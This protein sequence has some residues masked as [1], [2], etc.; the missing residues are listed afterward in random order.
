MYRNVIFIVAGLLLAQ[1][2]F[3]QRNNIWYFGVRGGLDFNNTGS[4][5][6]PAVLGNSAMVTNEG[7]SSICD[8]DGNLLFYSNGVTVYNR[9]HQVMLNGDNLAGDI[10]SVQACI[11]VPVPGN[12]NLFYIFTSDALEH[13]F[14]NGYTYSIVN[15]IGDGGKGEV[16]TKNAVLWGSCTERMVAARHANGTDVWLITNDNNSN[17]FRSWLINCNGLIT[18]PVVSSVGLVMNQHYTT[19]NGMLKVSPDAKKLCQTH[20]PEPDVTSFTPNFFQLF[21]FDNA[22]GAITNPRTVTLSNARVL[23]CEFSSDSKLLYLTNPSGKTIEQVEATLPTTSAIASSQLTINTSPSGYYGIQLAPDG[24]IYLADIGPALGAIN[25]PDVKGSGCNYVNRQITLA[26]GSSYL[27]LPAYINDFSANPTNG[28]SSSILDSCTGRVQFNSFTSMPGSIIWDWDFGDG[29]TSNQQNPIHSFTPVGQNYK[30]KLKISTVTGC[31]LVE[32][33]RVI[34]PGGL[35]ASA[36]FD[37]K[38]Y[39]DSGFVRFT[40]LSTIYPDTATIKYLWDFDDGNTST[41]SNP[42]H[43]FPAS[44]GSFDVRLSVLTSTACLDKSVTHTLDFE[45]LNIQASADQEI[46]AGQT[47]PLSVIGGG[48]SFVWTPARWLSD[49]SIS[50]PIATPGDNIT[51][52]VVVRNDAGCSDSDYVSIKVRPLPGI[53]MPTGFTPDNDGLNDLVKPIITKEFTLQ[54]FA[55]YN[56][57]GQKIFA[58][59]QI[60]AGWNGMINGVPQDSGVY[61]WIISA[62]DTRNNKKHELKGTFVIIRK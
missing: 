54:Q 2:S 50:N 13:S 24:K 41:A 18:T 32:R 46:D 4:G 57:W 40:N 21:D 3:A 60:G 56:R 44:G 8:S 10:S 62:T 30:V 5:P 34:F 31:G 1:Y 20:F 9:N 23:A 47:V 6:T 38:A 14:A 35:A 39:C 28:F 37:F 22:T 42:V 51:Y 29:N 27:S 61:A 53:Y 12:N 52:K 43:S 59:S 49:D 15:I 36:A 25:R 16:V 26:P 58:T 33:S 11:I 45:P 55:I 19:N 48:S 17:T 7:C